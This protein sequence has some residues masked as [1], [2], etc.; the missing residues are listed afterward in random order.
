MITPSSFV[1]RP[2][3]FFLLQS[4]CFRSVHSVL[5]PLPVVSLLSSLL[6]PSPHPLLVPSY[7][8]S[9]LC[10]SYLLHSP[11]L[12]SFS[13]HLL[14]F[15]SPPSP[16][17]SHLR[18]KILSGVL[19]VLE[20]VPDRSVTKEEHEELLEESTMVEGEYSGE[21]EQQTILVSSSSPLLFFL[22]S[23]FHFVGLTSVTYR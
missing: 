1:L 6:F 9:W 12:L 17:L 8:S 11:S 7:I 16:S 3:S 19:Q 23:S 15:T 5:L 18:V 4:C 14:L 13:S 10:F 21:L 22:L 2:S 20:L